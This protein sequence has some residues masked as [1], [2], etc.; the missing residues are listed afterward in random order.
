[1]LI[2]IGNRDGLVVFEDNDLAGQHLV[3]KT[4]D[5][6]YLVR[7]SEV[8]A[9]FNMIATLH[10]RHIDFTEVSISAEWEELVNKLAERKAERYY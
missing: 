6:M 1:M 8:F 2:P 9:L 10:D 4:E 7:E 3:F 5:Y